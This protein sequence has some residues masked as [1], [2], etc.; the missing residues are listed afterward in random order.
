MHDFNVP[1][2]FHPIYSQLN[3]PPR[4][5]FPIDKY[6]ALY[7]SLIHHGVLATR[8]YQ[9]EPLNIDQLHRLYDRQYIDALL[10]NRLTDKQMRRIGF[11]WS[12]QL[13]TR[14]LTACG[15][16]RL[17]GELAIEHGM[18]IN[19][20]G[21]Y[22]HAFSDFGSGFCMI[23]DLYLAAQHMLSYEHINR[24]LI[25][26]CDV[27]QGDGTACLAQNNED[28]VTVSLH[29][30]KNFPYRKQHSDLDFALQSQTNDNAYL[31]TVEQAL[32]VALNCYD[33]DAII[34]DAGV[35]IHQHDD[36]GH[37]NIT[38]N[39]IYER[40]YLVLKTALE[41]Q[42]PLAAVIGGGY[43]RDISALTKV[44]LQLFKAAHQLTKH[45]NRS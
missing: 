26:D 31:Q 12:E 25:F 32:T 14:T 43:Q 8:F 7:D 13:I 16:T 39:G 17:T 40:D 5:R 29:C 24:V 1:L 19:L 2:V 11:P 22:H 15:G 38:T 44:H 36:L 10:Y 41:R 28:I 42:L 6:Q 20:S 23:N 9:P 21:G 18:A 34:Y 45:T 4:H 30:E 35:D 3:L 33:V 27:H 37:F